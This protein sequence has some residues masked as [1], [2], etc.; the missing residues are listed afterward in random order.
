MSRLI[1]KKKMLPLA[2]SSQS[3]DSCTLKRIT[4]LLSNNL[5]FRCESG[6]V[7]V[8]ENHNRIFISKSCLRKLSCHEEYVDT[9]YRADQAA[10][11]PSI[12]SGSFFADSAC[13]PAIGS[14]GVE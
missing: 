9:E 1:D 2:Y 12:R 13:I 7:I 8:A 10:I 11:I 14:E 4:L 5:S 3:L 6:A